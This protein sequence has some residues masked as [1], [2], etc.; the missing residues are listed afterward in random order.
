[1]KFVKWALVIFVSTLVACATTENYEKLLNSWVSQPVGAL[2][3]SWGPPDSEFVNDSTRY[4]TWNKSETVFIPGTPPTY[5]TTMIGN[6][7]YTN[8]VAGT[9]SYN[10]SYSC[11]TTFTVRDGYVLSWRWE[12]NRCKA[13]SPK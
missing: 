6:T 10:A 7:A 1:M 5:R 9:P 4:L 2:I 3:D 13:H 8:T 11:K 12:G